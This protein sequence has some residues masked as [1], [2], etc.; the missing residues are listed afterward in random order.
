MQSD[1]EL[2][3]NSVAS[4]SVS[5][6]LDRITESSSRL[7]QSQ[8]STITNQPSLTTT[9]PP[10]FGAIIADEDEDLSVLHSIQ[11]LSNT[12]LNHSVSLNQSRTNDNSELLNYRRSDSFQQPS[13][14]DVSPVQPSRSWTVKLYPTQSPYQTSDCKLSAKIKD[15]T[16]E[17][18]EKK[19]ES[20]LYSNSVSSENYNYVSIEHADT[21][22][23][24]FRELWENNQ[25]CDV[26]LILGEQKFTAHRVI[27]CATIPY[28]YAMFTNDLAERTKTEVELQTNDSLDAEAFQS[29]L[30]YA[31]TGSI[32]INSA[33]VQSILIG[34]SFLGLTNVQQACADYLKIRLNVS[35][36][37]NIKGFANALGC[38]TLV[39]ASK[40]F[41]HRHFEAISKTTDF[42]NLDYEEVVDIIRKDEL[43]INGE[44]IVFDAIISWTKMDITK[45]EQYLPSILSHVR[46]PLLSPEYLTD[47]VMTEKLIRNSLQCRDLVDEAKD[48]HLMPQ[49]RELMQRFRT[50]PRFGNHIQG[51]IYA[52]GGL[53]KNGDSMSTVEV[54]DPHTKR[55]RIAES[56]TMLRSRVGV[57]VL[58][59]K[60]YAIGGYNGKERLNTLEVYDSRMKRWTKVTSMCYRRSAVGATSL[61][62]YLYVCGGYDG[63]SSLNVM[64]RYSATNDRWDQKALMN[65]QRSAAGVVAFDGYIYAF[66]GHDGL[67]IFNSVERYD[68]QT[69]QWEIVEPMLTRRCR[70]GVATFGGKIYVCG[71]YDGQTFLQ[72]AEVYDPYT[73]KWTQIA[74]MRVTRS[75]VAL[76]ANCGRLYAIGGYDGITNLSSVETYDV[77]RDCW[78]FT[79]SMV[80]HEG[81]VGVGVIPDCWRDKTL[82]D[83]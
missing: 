31:Y 79:S 16:D 15:S 57:A 24:V 30:H 71:G 40:R 37:L 3:G 25:V 69:D 19:S 62:G 14:S 77:E 76:V 83:F 36:V 21:S 80:A 60:L 12:Y 73:G 81:G 56:M 52:V 59:G 9:Y 48:Y 33:N 72:S 32:T 54:Y 68:P 46:L 39:V 63:I 82:D 47:N 7:D 20:I 8:M 26:T 70:L 11:A 13:S 44:E 64:E 28:F 74:P 53:T 22:F 5:E 29:L 75:R 23:P 10:S 61:N 67:M 45:R 66:G 18:N 51:L 6:N 35:N 1:S 41:I 38:E 65:Y 27:L 50:R 55:W 49:R 58:D 17:S 34:A 43:N 4:R 78:E 2:E 42:L